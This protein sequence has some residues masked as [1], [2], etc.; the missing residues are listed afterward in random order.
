MADTNSRFRNLIARHYMVPVFHINERVIRLDLAKNQQSNLNEI[1][2]DNYDAIVKLLKNYGHLITKLVYVRPPP[3]SPSFNA[4]IVEISENIAKYCA[5][6]LTEITLSSDE[7]YLLS[8]TNEIFNK[9][10][11]VNIVQLYSSQQPDSTFDGFFKM[12][13]IF[14]NMEELHLTPNAFKSMEN[15]YP[16]MKH[17][18]FSTTQSADDNKLTNLLLFNPQLRSVALNNFPHSSHLEFNN[19]F[20]PQLETLQIPFDNVNELASYHK[21]P[22]HFKNVKKFIVAVSERN[23]DVSTNFPITFEQL[24]ALEIISNYSTEVAFKLIEQN[25]KLKVLSMPHNDLYVLD[26]MNQWTELEQITAQWSSHIV[27]T[28]VQRLIG[29][30][31]KLTTITFVVPYQANG[32]DLIAILSDEWQFVRED[33]SGKYLT[34]ERNVVA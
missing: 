24:D 26:A 20:L 19:Q 4:E 23:F 13:K 12:H 10:I 2:F 16:K 31:E 15:L 17:L 28:E 22:V 9:V 3:S 1:H 8:Q 11:R 14:P 6:T 7:Y 29:N 5:K 27:E 18:E 32:D 33:H 25:D 21:N 34:F 30:A